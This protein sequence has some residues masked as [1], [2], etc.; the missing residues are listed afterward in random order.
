MKADGSRVSYSNKTFLSVVVKGLEEG[1]TSNSRRGTEWAGTSLL[2]E[3]VS[4]P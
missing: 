4:E 2:W 1:V 3:C